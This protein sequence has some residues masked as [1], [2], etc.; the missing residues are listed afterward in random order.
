MLVV[1]DISVLKALCQEQGPTVSNI[2]LPH[3]LSNE[4]F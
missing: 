3:S 1:E 4:L 2:R